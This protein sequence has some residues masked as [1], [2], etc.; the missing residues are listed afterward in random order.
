MADWLPNYQNLVVL[1]TMSKAW[2]AAGLRCGSVLAQPGVIGLLRR[3]IAPYP[4]PSP[5]VSLA[6][7]M[8]EPDS[9]Q[10]QAMLLDEVRQQKTRLVALLQNRSFVQQLYPGEANFVL[11]STPD[12]DGLLSFCAARNII[13]R[14]FPAD[15]DLRD[16]IRISVGTAAELD[17]L[18]QALDEW[19]KFS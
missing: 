16:C 14:G 10:R 11:F 12:A 7:A 3:I 8:L 15:P 18:K 13:L 6:L 9:A 4:L 1:R 19:E 5:V 2:A 17:A